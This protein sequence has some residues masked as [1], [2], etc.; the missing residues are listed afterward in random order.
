MTDPHPGP[1]PRTHPAGR[2]PRWPRPDT[3]GYEEDP[4]I[5]AKAFEGLHNSAAFEQAG[6]FDIL[7]VANYARLFAGIGS[8]GP[9][10][11]SRSSRSGT[12]TKANRTDESLAP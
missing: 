5:D 3:R 10:A 4:G 9:S 11:V 7:S 8:G 6:E 12:F 1:A 2:R